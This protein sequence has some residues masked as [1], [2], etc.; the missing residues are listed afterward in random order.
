M[1]SENIRPILIIEQITARLKDDIVMAR[2]EPGS[3]LRE[4]ELQKRFNV[5]RSPIREALRELERQGFVQIFSRKG[6]FVRVLT[7]REIKNIYDVRAVLEGLAAEKTFQRDKTA[8]RQLKTCLYDMA[9]AY[10][11]KDRETYLKAHD[12]FHKVWISGCG[13]AFLTEEAMRLKGLSTWFSVY[14]QF[15]ELA[16]ENAI[17]VHEKIVDVF[18][19]DKATPEQ[20]N[21]CVR[22]NILEGAD[23]IRA[24]IAQSQGIETNEA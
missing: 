16:F 14:S 8:V 24:K 5:S 21:E 15:D 6:A 17:K 2:I 23:R 11:A 13:N 18:S 20:V 3:A 22:N 1:E 7:L 10:Q 19:S 12:A 4:T 9:Q